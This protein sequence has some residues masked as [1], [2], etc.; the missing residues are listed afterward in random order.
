MLPI[1]VMLGVQT[2]V[3]DLD[4]SNFSHANDWRSMLLIA[5]RARSTVFY[6]C[7][8]RI[9]SLQINSWL[10]L[11][12]LFDTKPFEGKFHVWWTF[13]SFTVLSTKRLNARRIHSVSLH[14]TETQKGKLGIARNSFPI[15]TWNLSSPGNQ[16]GNNHVAF[17][18]MVWG[19]V[20]QPLDIPF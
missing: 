7:L 20:L 11:M 17:S 18:L 13:V 3:M 4:R 2:L 14:R 6:T 8:I 1:L 10:L 15:H 9:I 5:L 16:C 19:R 12:Q